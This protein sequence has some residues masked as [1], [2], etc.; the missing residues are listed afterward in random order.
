MKTQELK[1]D[2]WLK[3][4]KL[5]DHTWFNHLGF[6]IIIVVI[7]TI[8]SHSD[9]SFAYKFFIMSANITFYAIIIYTNILYLFPKYMADR[10][11]GKHLLILMIF[12]ALL[13]PIKTLFMYYIVKDSESKFTVLYN[14]YF[15][16]LSTFF[17]GIASSIYSI[18][19]DWMK[20]QREKQELT[21]KTLQSE[22]N[23]LKSQINPHFL[24]N[25]LNS[26]YALTLKKSDLAPE[27]VLK[28]SEM[29]R[30]ML[31]ECN[32]KQ[33]S[34]SKELTYMQNYLELERLR[35]GKKMSISLNMKG[36]PGEKKI[37]PLMFIPFIENCFKHGISHHIADGFV[38]IDI[39]IN[40]FDIDI[41]IENSKAPALPGFNGKKSGGIGLVNI[42]RR[43]ELLYP[44]NYLL[45]I[46]ESPN[47]YKVNLKLNLNN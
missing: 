34:L 27:I 12:A 46:S 31:Y 45:N 41:V 6:W 26:L 15:E 10:K 20:G 19:N 30:Y 42:K 24:F 4:K 47:T 7:M 43:L 37:A 28:L 32:E 1:V 23:F 36:E 38:N 18:L 29:M 25:T 16:F 21:T 44:E 8:L 17:I 35:Q 33:V 2:V 40:R 3:L 14:Q 11:L 39:A 22:L 5:T 13:M 9:D